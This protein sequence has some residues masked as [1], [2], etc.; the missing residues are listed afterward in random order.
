MGK[1]VL[2][3]DEEFCNLLNFLAERICRFVLDNKATQR[4]DKVR[5]SV[6][7]MVI[8]IRQGHTRWSTTVQSN[9][10]KVQGKLF[11]R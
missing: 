2:P 5:I 10:V 1:L 8:I 6:A 3:S 7:F 9:K 4:M 11:L